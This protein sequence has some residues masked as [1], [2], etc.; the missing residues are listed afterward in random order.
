MLQSEV[1]TLS[2]LNIGEPPRDQEQGKQM[3][4]GTEPSPIQLEKD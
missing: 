1:F 2:S 3:S 4:F